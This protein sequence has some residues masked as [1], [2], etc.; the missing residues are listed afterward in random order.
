MKAKKEINIDHLESRPLT[1]SEEKE[2]SE[3]IKFLKQQSNKPK[4]KAA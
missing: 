1:Q 3:F 4:K 2:L